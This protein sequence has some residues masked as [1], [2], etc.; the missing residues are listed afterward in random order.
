MD[1]HR[2]ILPKEIASYKPVHMPSPSLW[3]SNVEL[4]IQPTTLVILPWQAVPER[5]VNALLRNGP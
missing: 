3:P 4:V 5:L 2:N 1:L